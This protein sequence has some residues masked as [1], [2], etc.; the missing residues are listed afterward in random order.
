[1]RQRNED[2]WRLN[3][4]IYKVTHVVTKFTEET[5]CTGSGSLQES[6]FALEFKVHTYHSTIV[7]HKTAIKTWSGL[8]KLQQW[9][10][11]D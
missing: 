11:N 7:G 8:G 5:V 2:D 10:I 6:N 3:F 4:C 1:M 9:I